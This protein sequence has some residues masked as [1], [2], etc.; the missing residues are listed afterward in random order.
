MAG[1]LILLALVGYL[2]AANV[3]GDERIAAFWGRPSGD[4]QVRRLDVPTQPVTRFGVP[5][6]GLPAP[7]PD[8]HHDE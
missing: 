2:E 4:E 1:I 8:K 3:R 7:V 6:H 5:F